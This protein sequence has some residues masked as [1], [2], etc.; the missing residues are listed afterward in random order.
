MQENVHESIRAKLIPYVQMYEFEGLL[1]SSPEYIASNL[2][3][4]K[5]VAWARSILAEFSNNPEKINNS[6]KT[7]P[8]KRFERD[9][10]YR[11]TT[12]GPNIS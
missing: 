6:P 2:H 7:A 4:E 3:D 1:F 12:H 11:K 5:L 9:T 10:I 8:S